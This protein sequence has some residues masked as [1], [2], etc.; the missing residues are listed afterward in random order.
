MG[1][2]ILINRTKTYMSKFYAALAGLATL[3][4]TADAKYSWGKCP[5]VD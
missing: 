3:S 2:N 4:G 5:Q 1:K